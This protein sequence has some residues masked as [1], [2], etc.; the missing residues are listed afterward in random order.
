METI[1]ELLC[2]S[3]STIRHGK[4]L[5]VLWCGHGPC[6]MVVQPAL[7][8]L[9]VCMKSHLQHRGAWHP[10]LQILQSLKLKEKEFDNMGSK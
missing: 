1:E 5:L 2:S 10:Q 8:L 6:V 9:L 7:A 4:H 3:V